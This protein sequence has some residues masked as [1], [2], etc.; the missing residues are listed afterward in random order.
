MATQQISPPKR[1]LTLEDLQHMPNV[2]LSHR[3]LA[4]LTTSPRQWISRISYC[5]TH[6]PDG[7]VLA[8]YAPNRA[9]PG[10]TLRVAVEWK[11]KNSGT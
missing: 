10:S 8:V 3:A 4:R 6:L 1:A 11:I 5:A 2:R 7:R 9:V